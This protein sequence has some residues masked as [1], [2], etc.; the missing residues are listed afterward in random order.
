M[1][2][3]HI[4]LDEGWQRIFKSIFMLFFLSIP[5]I[6]SLIHPK[7]RE[8]LKNAIEDND[9]RLD[10]EDLDRLGRLM[11]LVYSHIILGFMVLSSG[12]MGFSYPA[13]AWYIIG[14]VTMG[15]DGLVLSRYL[16]KKGKKE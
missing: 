13:E 14:G 1:S 6:I 15:A 2:D 11:A 9:K 12:M 4:F 5:I 16:K 8:W 3:N 7:I 10:A